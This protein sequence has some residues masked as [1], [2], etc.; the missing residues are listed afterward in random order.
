M[1]NRITTTL[2]PII[3]SLTSFSG[4]DWIIS[5]E[6]FR[7]LMHII[8][9]LMLTLLCSYL[10]WGEK[11]SSSLIVSH[12]KIDYPTIQF[13]THLN[14][15][16]VKW[17]RSRDPNNTTM[18]SCLTTLDIHKYSYDACQV[19]WSSSGTK[20]LEYIWYHI[21]WGICCGNFE[22]YIWIG[23][24]YICLVNRHSQFNWLSYQGKYHDRL[25]LQFV[26]CLNSAKLSEY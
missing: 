2:L 22:T 23:F 8:R 19:N 21:S 11:T 10:F 17:V 15:L 26:L 18:Y 4:V 9:M 20:N 14:S 12:C 24:V 16:V 6:S 13:K 1:T 7:F 5:K 25:T 3:D